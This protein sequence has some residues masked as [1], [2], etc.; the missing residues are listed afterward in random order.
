MS[1][2]TVQVCSIWRECR[3]PCCLRCLTLLRRF[4]QF[5]QNVAFHAIWRCRRHVSVDGISLSIDEKFGEIPLNIPSSKPTCRSRLF[6]LQE[7]PKRMLRIPIHVH[8][9][10]KIK[11]DA[12]LLQNASFNLGICTR[13][14]TTKLIA[15]ESRNSQP[16]GF[17]SFVQSLKLIVVGVGQP[18]VGCYV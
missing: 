1:H 12:V 3:F 13:L 18:S 11:C 2:T 14:L 10:E 7:R 6:P 9:C 4:V 5:G 16:S 17:V 15:G 8:L